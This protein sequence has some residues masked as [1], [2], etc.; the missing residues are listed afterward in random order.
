MFCVLL[1]LDRMAI[2]RKQFMESM[3]AHG[4]GTGISYEA[5]HLTTVGRDLGYGEGMFPNTERIARETLTLPLFPDMTD[6]DVMRVCDT[7]ELVMRSAL[8]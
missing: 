4:I 6:T 1:P 5:L 3:H 7:L 2:T 8:K